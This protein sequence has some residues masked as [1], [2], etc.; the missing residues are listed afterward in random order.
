MEKNKYPKFLKRKDWAQTPAIFTKSSLL[1][2]D[3]QIMQRWENNY[4]KMLAGIV[5]RKGGDI[6]EVG[7]GLGISAGF[8]QKYPKVKNHT[9]VEFHPDVINNSKKMFGGKIKILK[10]FWEE[11][12]PNIKKNSFDAI[13]FDAYPLSKN[14]ISK[15]RM[16]FLKESFRI[17]RKGGIL[18][19]YSDIDNCKNFL[20]EYGEKIKKLGFS[21]VNCKPCKVNPPKDC[22]YY[23]KKTI[24]AP[25][26]KK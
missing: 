23:N 7:F 1:I 20:K 9:V 21:E 26:I 18:T 24:I 12:V 22:N 3:H 25:I 13:L 4:M 17:L 16:H 6:L 10:G 5:G 19:Y 11:V 15:T 2:A 14:E 8:I